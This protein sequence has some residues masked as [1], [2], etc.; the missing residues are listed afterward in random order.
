MYKYKVY[1]EIYKCI[2][3]QPNQFLSHIYIYVCVCVNICVHTYICKTKDTSN[4]GFTLF[5]LKP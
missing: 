3:T 4:S 2:D 5:L 1:V